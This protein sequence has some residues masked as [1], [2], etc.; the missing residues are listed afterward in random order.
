MSKPTRLTLAVAFLFCAFA[1]CLETDSANGDDW[2]HWR[3]DGGNG[4]ATNAKPPVTW[5][6]T[7]NIKWKVKIPGKGSGSPIIWGDKVFVVTAV[8]SDGKEEPK[9]AAGGGGRGGPRG[10]AR[11][12]RGGGRGGRGAST[13]LPKLQFKVMCFNRENGEV[14]WEKM[15]TESTPHEG[16]HST[17]NYA[18]ASP[19]TDGEHVYAHFGSRGVYCYTMD[20]ELKW[21]RD[22]LGEMK[23]RASFGE[24]SSPVLAGDKL[25]VPWDHEGP[26]SL[27]ALN[28]ANGETIWKTDRDEPTNWATPLVIEHEGK[29][30]VVM[31]GQ[32]AARSYD[33][34]TGK[35]LWHCGGQTDRPCASAVAG[36]G[37]VYVGSGHRGAFLAAFSPGGKGDVKG[38]E[39]VVWSVNRDTPDI[40]S[41]LLSQGRLYFY[42]A[43]EGII[44]CLDAAT[45]KPHYNATRVPRLT[46]KIYASPIAANGHVYL[47]DRNGTT[48]VIKDSDEFSVVAN[49]SVGETVDATPAPVDNQLFIRGES[50]LFCIQE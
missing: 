43:K 42:K 29:K 15:A 31:N 47:T 39:N 4:V 8:R 45:G 6:D 18:S 33:L 44:S 5:S 12:S 11:G 28:K 41:P 26:S 17:N 46:G 48:V 24:G 30:Q 23:A 21:K 13:P 20:G 9:A 36:D 3:G 32:T 49:N 35:E 25:I 34:E 10:G 16:T 2:G 37:L 22:D 7:E 27:Y 38:T 19:C 40:A 50:H 1:F 14:V